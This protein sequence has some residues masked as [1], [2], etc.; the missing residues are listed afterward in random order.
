M[1]PDQGNRNTLRLPRRFGCRYWFWRF[2]KISDQS[3]VERFELCINPS[4]VN[5]RSSSEI[6]S[7]LESHLW[8]TQSAEKGPFGTISRFA[9]TKCGDEFV[10]MLT[11]ARKLVEE[12]SS[13]LEVSVENVVFR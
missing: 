6:Q 3:K 1:S 8:E 2:V 13:E 5:P 4:A 7:V 12:T 11:S 9:C 10:A